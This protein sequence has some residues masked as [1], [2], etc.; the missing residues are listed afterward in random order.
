MKQSTLALAKLTAFITFVIACIY[1]RAGVER[2]VSNCINKIHPMNNTYSLPKLI[3]LLLIFAG[4][5]TESIA[6]TNTAITNNGDWN[7]AGTWSLNRVPASGDDIVIPAGIT[8]HVN[9]NSPTYSAMTIAVNGT[10][11]FGTGQKIN[12]DCDGYVYIG[13]TGQLTGGVSGSKINI[14]GS[15]VWNGPGPTGGPTGY[16][17]APL[18]IE[19]VAFTAV[20]DKT[21][22]VLKWTTATEENN[23]YFTIERSRNGIS[24]ETMT[25]ID[26]AGNSSSEKSYAAKDASPLEGTSYYRLKQT[27]F[28]GTYTYSQL[29]AVDYQETSSG[30][31]LKVYPNPCMGGPCNVDLA[32]CDNEESS[33]M[34]VE[35]I[36][37]SGNKV[38]SNIPERDSK[39]SFS[40]SI[41]KTNNL[42]PGVYIV[43]GV[44]KNEQYN[45]KMIIK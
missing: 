45:K 35:L 15:T 21:E 41:D 24:F 39:G 30:C 14:C 44:S 1:C 42:K 11:N 29:I 2:I 20:L 37:A 22:V 4:F 40:L 19:L 13:P 3:V 33:E 32:E 43:R 31:V 26:G 10:L 6:I 23:D 5:S 18:P 27:D 25:T 17:T 9:I 38:Y 8:V 36:D 34:T 28:N 7:T 16:G 12:L